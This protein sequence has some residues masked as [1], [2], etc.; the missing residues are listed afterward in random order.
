M[1]NIDHHHHVISISIIIIIIII[2]VAAVS[3]LLTCHETAMI[4]RWTV[5]QP[6]ESASEGE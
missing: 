3:E 6:E 5:Q 2:R 1:K 4:I